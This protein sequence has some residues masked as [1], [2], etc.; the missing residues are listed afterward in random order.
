V[1]L[2]NGKATLKLDKFTSTGKR[3]IRVDYQG[4]DFLE[5]SAD[6]VK[7]KVVKK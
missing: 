2:R 1:T 6:T 3:T 7:I 5:P 4:S